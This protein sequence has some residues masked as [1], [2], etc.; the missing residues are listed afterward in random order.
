MTSS[1][2]PA[3]KAG[4]KI[5]SPELI[6]QIAAG[7]VIERPA[8]AIKE[9]VENAIDAKASH[10]TIDVLNAGKKLIQVIDD[11]VGMSE[12]EIGLAL[13]RHATSK[14]S[15]VDDLFNITSLGFRGEALPSINSISNL[16]IEKNRS[17]N[18]LS[19]IVKDLFYNVPARLKFLKKDST[20]IGQIVDLTSRLILSNPEISFKLSIDSKL[21]L[22]SSGNGKLLDAILSVYG[23]EI[24]KNLVEV[25]TENIKGYISRPS[26]SR[27]DRSYESFF[28]NGRYVKNFLLGKAVEEAF[29]NLIPNNRYPFA[30]IFLNVPPS[31]VDV[32][33]HPQKRE[34]KFLKTQEIMSNLSMAVGEALTPA[35]KAPLISDLESRPLTKGENGLPLNQ[36]SFGAIDEIPSYAPRQAH[37]EEVEILISDI[38]PYI[39][40]YQHL[41]TYIIATDGVDLVMIDQHAAHERI[42]F[43]KL[44]LKKEEIHLQ[45]LL[46]P[47]SFDLLKSQ[48]LIL[49]ENL[50]YFKDLGFDIEHFG[51]NSFILRTVPSYFKG[52][53]KSTIDELLNV[54]EEE[55]KSKSG[56]NKD[57]MLKL[58]AC[59]SA[60]KAG[61]K[62]SNQEIRRLISDLFKTENPLTCPHGRPTMVK[63]S[64]HDFQK[65]FGRIN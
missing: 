14:I 28:V 3:G 11:G 54:L 52:D 6:N 22:H 61:D 10:I 5:L 57:K 16:K 9:L 18:G 38:Q 39:P 47:E 33:V 4:I 32:N 24:T 19:V 62:L 31:E 65:L 56:K 37:S 41:D 25:N 26:I 20:E 53:F 50:P 1:N 44:I 51:G 7:E 12:E 48:A 21:V 23:V 8:S 13:E 63:F 49:F 15:S 58:I 27:V 43:D 64:D 40:I 46:I 35:I 36:M 42:L 59:H 55:R 30:A 45:N 17:G 2:L 60:I 29:R 34:I